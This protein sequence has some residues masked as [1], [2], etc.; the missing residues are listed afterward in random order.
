[1][2][3]TGLNTAARNVE[4]Q[5]SAHIVISKESVVN[6]MVQVFVNTIYRRQHVRNVSSHRIISV[7]YVRLSAL[8]R[9]LEDIHFAIDV[10]VSPTLMSLYQV[11]L[12]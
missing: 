1:M 4:A 9:I 2:S 8:L 5:Q 12:K 7:K 11:D 10:T 6:V 3:T